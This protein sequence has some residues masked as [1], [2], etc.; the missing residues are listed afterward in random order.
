M[1]AHQQLSAHD[2]RFR[3]KQSHLSF[4][5]KLFDIPSNNFVMLTAVL[6]F[7]RTGH[8][9]LAISIA[10]GHM[11]VFFL[12]CQFTGALARAYNNNELA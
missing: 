7:L 6:F 11:G 2:V 3:H 5:R 4:H 9:K 12:L 8:L 10:E 1:G